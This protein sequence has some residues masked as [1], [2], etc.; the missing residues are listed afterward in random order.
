MNSCAYLMCQHILKQLLSEK[1]D[2]HSNLEYVF[3]DMINTDFQ[4]YIESFPA[5]QAYKP[6]QQG[7][8][9]LVIAFS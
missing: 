1:R 8:C 7:L 2:V 9:I 4:N 5:C 3:W 6:N